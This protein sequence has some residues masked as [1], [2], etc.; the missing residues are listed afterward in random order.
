[1]RNAEL[2]EAQVGIKIAERIIYNFRYADD[3]TL[4]QESEKLKGL[5]MK[6]REDGERVGS[7]LSIQK[8][9]I[10]ASCHGK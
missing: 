7:K 2:H 5:L 10:M 1:M 4:M 8:T 9:K 3:T 6:V